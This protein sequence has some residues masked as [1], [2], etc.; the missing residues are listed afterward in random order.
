MYKLVIEN[1]NGSDEVEG[2]NLVS[3]LFTSELG[4]SDYSNDVTITNYL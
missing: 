3:Y 1:E 4:R 2:K